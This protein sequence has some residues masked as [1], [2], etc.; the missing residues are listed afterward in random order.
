[1]R[2]AKP[3]SASSAASWSKADRRYQ[4]RDRVPHRLAMAQFGKTAGDLLGIGQQPIA[5][6]LVIARRGFCRF[7]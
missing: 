5:A 1:M 3:R 6:A 7:D 4:Q 2:R